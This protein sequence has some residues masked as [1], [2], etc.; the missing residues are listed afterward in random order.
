MAGDILAS[1][2]RL[3]RRRV[4]RRYFRILIIPFILPVFLVFLAYLPWFRIQEIEITGGEE[5]EGVIK[6]LIKENLKKKFFLVFPKDNFFLIDKENLI[7]EIA[8]AFAEIEKVNLKKSF[9]SR[10]IKVEIKNRRIFAFIC[11][12]P[13]CFYL[14]DE[15]NIFKESP[16]ISGAL[17]LEVVASSSAREKLSLGGSVDG[18]NFKKISFLA[19]KF[20]ENY[21]EKP[22]KIILSENVSELILASGL[23]IILDLE[24]EPEKILRNLDIALQNAKDRKNLEYIDLR[25]GN[26]VYYKFR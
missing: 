22:S 8:K 12:E 16:L 9:I 6:D 7:R 10:K 26:K 13:N 19:K 1:S 21:K 25:F 18:E 20:E 14:D 3:K 5:K 23:K 2:R 11:D 4:I 17:M 15:G 24:N